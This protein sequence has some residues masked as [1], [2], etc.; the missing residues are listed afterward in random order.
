M[1]TPGSDP[2]LD[3][4]VD[5][6]RR[7][8]PGEPLSGICAPRAGSQSHEA[9]FEERRIRAIDENTERLRPAIAIAGIIN[10]P[11]SRSSA[12]ISREFGLTPSSRIGSTG[13]PGSGCARG[14][15]VAEYR[16]E[17][18]AYCQTD[19]W[20]EIRSKPENRSVAGARSAI[21]CR[22]PVSPARLSA[23]SP[24]KR[25]VLRDLYGTVPA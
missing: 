8:R 13:E 10:T 25:K 9:G 1:E 14:Q 20:C 3:A 7:H 16:K 19:T 24:G 12:R 23:P 15:V 22:D 4:R 11:E 5:G 18:C 6:G 2:H 17:T 21:L